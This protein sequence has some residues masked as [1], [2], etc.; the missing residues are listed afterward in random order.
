M[1]PYSDLSR[2]IH[3][4]GYIFILI[5]AVAA[6][7]L[8]SFSANLGWIGAI[9]TC[10]CAF[11]FRNP[12]RVTPLA[13][14]LVISPADGVVQSIKEIAA[15]AELGLGD[16]PMTRISIFLSV[17]NVHV[18]RIPV[19]GKV[20]SLNYHP[21]KFIN[22]SLDKASVHNERQS[23]LIETNKKVKIA[24]VQIAGLIA[25]R[26]ICDL[27][28]NQEVFTGQRF[29]I[30]RFGSR[31]DIYLPAQT[32]ILVSEGQTCVSGETIIA[33]FSKHKGAEPEFVSRQ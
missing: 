17:F 12:D 15:P 13:E 30:I 25:R 14:D 20:L 23:I 27:E 2:I 5:F 24:V 21:G 8:A 11:F 1:K 31:V 4:E 33:N 9:A 7:V 6:F 10:W 18:N 28:E 16:V 29:G 32:A 19:D 26:I 22:A 3:R